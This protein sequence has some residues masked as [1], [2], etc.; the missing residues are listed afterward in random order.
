MMVAV[1]LL[2]SVVPDAYFEQYE[3]EPFDDVISENGELTRDIKQLREY[4][5]GDRLKDIHWKASASAG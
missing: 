3:G 5:P 2:I 4:S 1:V